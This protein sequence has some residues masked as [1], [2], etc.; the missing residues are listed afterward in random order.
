MIAQ[1][2]ELAPPPAPPGPSFFFD[3]RTYSHT[4]DGKR[5][6]RQFADVLAYVADGR[7][8]TL[9]EIAQAVRAPEASVSARLRDARKARFGGFAIERE[10]VS[11]GLHRYRLSRRGVAS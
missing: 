8:H 5:L 2:L 1:Q 11:E 3:G 10:Y 7:W 6:S 4:R 9:A